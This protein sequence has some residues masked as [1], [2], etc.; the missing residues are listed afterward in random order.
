MTNNKKVI[1]RINGQDFT[2]VGNESEEYV[3]GIANFVDENIKEIVKKNSKLSQSMSAILAAFNI[4]DKYYRNSTELSQIK[5]N[6]VEPL[7]ELESIKAE[8]VDSKTKAETLKYECD[9]YKDELLQSKRELEHLHKK[10]RQYEQ[11]LKLKEDELLNTQKM[12][13]ELQNK[14]FE[15][16][17]EL[18]QTKKELEE[19]LRILDKD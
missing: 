2:V 18:V 5:E 17:I 3:K 19:S 15:N 10:L 9:T 4:A 12:I 8:L 6:V 14:L 13:N 1:V 16:Q 7:K 11:S